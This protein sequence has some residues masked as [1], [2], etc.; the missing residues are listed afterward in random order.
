M[1]YK[2][3][4]N[5][6]IRCIVN[7]DKPK[8]DNIP[9]IDKLDSLNKINTKLVLPE[10]NDTSHIKLYI[11]SLNDSKI[12]KLYRAISID[13]NLCAIRDRFINEDINT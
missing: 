3:I 5:E 10:K 9:N 8:I 13:L 2:E 4:R 1:V 11:T 12:N 7:N 6:I